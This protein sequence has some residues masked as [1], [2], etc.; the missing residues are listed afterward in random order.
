MYTS[1]GELPPKMGEECEPE[2]PEENL[3]LR[4]TIELEPSREPEQL[5]IE[6]APEYVPQD[7]YLE[8][9]QERERQEEL[10]KMIPKR[11]P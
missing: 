6:R 11:I 4:I 2:V 1:H 7:D 9:E 5:V 3:E 10:G 8:K